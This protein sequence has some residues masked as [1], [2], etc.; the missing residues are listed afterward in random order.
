[1]H[2]SDSPENAATEI[3][4]CFSESEIVG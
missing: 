3:A 2:G 1:V 4:L